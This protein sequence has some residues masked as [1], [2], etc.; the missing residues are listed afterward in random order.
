MLD[1]IGDGA[2]GALDR[3]DCGRI[4]PEQVSQ[5]AQLVRVVPVHPHP[6]PDRLL[7]LARGVGQ[8][9]LL[10]ECHELGDAERLDVA[11]GGE[12]EVAFDVDL[13]PQALA[14][15]PVLVALVLAEHRVEA[16]VEVLVGTAPG[17]MDAHRI[18]GGDGAVE[19]AP[20]GPAGVLGAQPREGPSVAPGVE[21]LVL[22]GDEIGLRIDGSEH[23]ASGSGWVG[24][25]GVGR[26][27]VGAD[28][29]AAR[30]G[31]SEYPTRD[32]RT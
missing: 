30:F 3:R 23:S 27:V 15:E 21:D 5:A 26:R 14:V 22:L 6:E 12:A 11:L 19:E 31:G 1:R 20:P 4:G 18:V 17:V 8:H 10:A 16:L 25:R 2:V 7:G 29:P 32:A 24:S 13:H 9:A 28:G